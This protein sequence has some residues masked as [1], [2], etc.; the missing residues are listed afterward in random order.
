MLTILIKTVRKY[1]LKNQLRKEMSTLICYTSI[2]VVM[3]LFRSIFL[4]FFHQYYKIVC[5]RTIRFIVNN[6]LP[7]LWDFPPICAVLYLHY[8]NFKG[9]GVGAKASEQLESIISLEYYPSIPSSFLSTY[10][11][12]QE[13]DQEISSVYKTTIESTSVRT[14]ST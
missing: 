3:Y 11:S 6:T 9:Q 14:L 13:E 1:I 12:A 10:R 5:N 8:K 7:V 2:F 4:V